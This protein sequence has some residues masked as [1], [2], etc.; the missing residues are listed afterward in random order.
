MFRS[1]VP[2]GAAGSEVNI[3]AIDRQGKRD[4]LGFVLRPRAQSPAPADIAPAAGVAP[5]V[6]LPPLDLGKFYALVIG[7]NDYTGLP[8]LDTAVADAE[9]VG[10]TLRDKYGFEVTLLQNAN[11][12]QILS[13]LNQYRATLT[14]HDNLLI[15]YAGHGEL[16]ETNQ[17]GHWL[18]VDAEPDSTANWISNVQITDILNAMSAKRVLVV[19][20][21]C[22]SGAL[23]RASLAQL[24]SGMSEEAR[25]SWLRALAKNR[26]R[27]ALTSGGLQPTLDSGGGGHSVFARALLEV[28]DSNN[29]LIEGQ[30]LHREVSARVTYAAEQVRFEQVPQ[31]APIKHAGHEAGE[32]FLVP[33]I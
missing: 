24:D 19:A 9:A 27:T 26:S 10:R 7:N 17:R 18:P 14:E 12:Y 25:L 15:Y 6:K 32:F 16:D 13:A 23:T 20:D 11:R 31:Y 28:L 1:T 3:V 4:E 8:R 21:S 29:D 30:R 2:L 22:Y 33:K 5:V